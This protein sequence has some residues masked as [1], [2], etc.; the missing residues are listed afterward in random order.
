MNVFLVLILLLTTSAGAQDKSETVRRLIAQ[1]KSDL[2]TS[3]D[4]A[5]LYTRLGLLYVRMDEADSAQSAFEK[6]LQLK[7]EFAVALTGLGRI[8]LEIRNRPNE[9]LPYFESPTIVHPLSA[10][11]TRI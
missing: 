5:S 9:A 2:A 8:E 7:P 4:P 10:R 11:C 3:A 1:L 6:S